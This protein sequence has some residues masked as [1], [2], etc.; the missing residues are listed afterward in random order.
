MYIKLEQYKIFNEAAT[1]LSFSIAARNLFISQSAVSQTISSIEKELQTQLFIRHS[2]GVSLTKEGKLLHQQ[3]DKAVAIITSVENQISNFHELKDG[4]LTIGA[5][6]TFSEYFLTDYIVK[7]KQ[8]YPGVKIKVINRTSLE[9]REL[10][11]T[12]QIDLGFLNLPIKDDALIIKECFQVQDIFVSNQKDPHIYT[13]EE[14]AKKSLIL[15]EKSSNT[16]NR[17]DNFFAKKGI[18]LN[19]SIELGAHNLLLDF[20]KAGLG[21]SCV[22]KEFSQEYLNQNILHE[23]K[24][25]SSLPRR[26]IGYAYLKRRTQSVATNKFIE[27]IANDNQNNINY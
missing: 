3:I 6:D 18:L 11:K 16:R 23:V 5:G 1:T 22:I 21:I 26:S 8:L 24:T 17:I 20:A 10:L 2:K 19:P 25:I 27:L 12:D 4:Q 15:F 14:L 9:T 13:F 7:F